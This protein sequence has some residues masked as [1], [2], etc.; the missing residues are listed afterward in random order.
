[1]HPAKKKMKLR[2]ARKTKV[3]PKQLQ[4]LDE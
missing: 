1:M 2:L 4:K 3:Y